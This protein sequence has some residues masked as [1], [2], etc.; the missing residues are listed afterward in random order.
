MRENRLGV[1][2]VAMLSNGLDERLHVGI[3]HGPG[4]EARGGQGFG[5]VWLDDTG[6]SVLRWTTKLEGSGGYWVEISMDPL[7]LSQAEDLVLPSGMLPT[8]SVVATLARSQDGVVIARSRLGGK[9]L[10]DA[11]LIR[12]ATIRAMLT[13]AFG[14]E[15]GISQMD[16]MDRLTAYRAMPEL[17]LIA[18]ASAPTDDMLAL[19]RLRAQWWLAVPLALVALQLGLAG[20]FLGWVTRRRQRAVRLGLERSADAE[21]AARVALE[22]L[23][24]CSPAMLYRGHLDP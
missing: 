2:E 6:L 16:G 23:L 7:A 5:P 1:S 10:E 19:A 9:H 17:G 3:R 8:S 11:T 14:S 12:P 21:A 18:M 22:D 15:R 24:R 13:Q 20:L 4:L